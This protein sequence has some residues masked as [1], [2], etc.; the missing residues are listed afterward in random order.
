MISGQ[1]VCGAS[2]GLYHGGGFVIGSLFTYEPYCAE[3]ARL[4]DL[5]VISI[6]YRLSPDTPS[7]PCRRL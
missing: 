5:P 4:L 3:V 7:R 1:T 2:H 6:D